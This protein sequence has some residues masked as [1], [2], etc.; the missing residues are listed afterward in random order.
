MLNAM[1]LG[2]VLNDL[3]YQVR[4]YEAK[5]GETDRTFHEAVD[6]LCDDLRNRNSFEI[7]E[8]APEWAKPK[9]KS[10]KVLR[11]TFNVFGKWH[12][13]MVRPTPARRHAPGIRTYGSC[14]HPR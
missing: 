5:Q 1:H 6:A 4:P 10:N 12:E 9:F 8:R 14:R 7:E 2:D 11:N 13:H 3:I